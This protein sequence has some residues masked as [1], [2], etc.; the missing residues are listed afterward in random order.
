MTKK[1]KNE[2]QESMF[3]LVTNI[4]NTPDVTT[5]SK[6][7]EKKSPLEAIMAEMAEIAGVICVDDFVD[8]YDE[9]EH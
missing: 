7:V 3:D 5:I 6:S 1:Q 4:L 8:D 2:K 9:E